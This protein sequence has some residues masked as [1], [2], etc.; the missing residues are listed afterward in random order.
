MISI[1]NTNLKFVLVTTLSA[2]LLTGCGGGGGGGEGGSTTVFTPT[3]NTKPQASSEASS[4]SAPK[5]S[6]SSKSSS[7]SNS[8]AS[9][10]R[11]GADLAAPILTSEVNIEIAE[12][13]MTLFT[14]AAA[15]DNVGVVAYKIYRDQI[16]IDQIEAND[17]LYADFNVAPNSDYTYGVSAGDA[18]GNWSPIKTVGARTKPQPVGSIVTSS[19]SSS[20][21]S[22]SL[23]SNSSSTSNPSS[24][25]SSQNSSAASSSSASIDTQAPSTPASIHK[26]SASAF[27]VDIGWTAASDNIGIASYKVYRDNLL[28]ATLTGSSLTYSDPSTQA[29]KTYLYGIE[30]LDAAGNKSPSQKTILV[31]TPSNINGD[32][33]LHWAPPTQ[34]ENGNAIAAT[35]LGGF[36]LRYKAKTDT[37][38][39]E[40]DIKDGSAKSRT[41][42]L[43]V[44]EYEFELAAYD[45]NGLHSS[46]NKLLPN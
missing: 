32:L 6:S 30:A 11:G 41:I 40:L 10:G 39:I 4:S 22:M 46:F 38:Y 45:T 23:A 29:I 7:V 13:D 44:G 16:Q 26:I 21:T 25:S 1:F 37:D 33:A 43:P 9:S 3:T 17:P 8:S 24:T 5:S 42:T 34:R 12:F 27:K 20:S 36:L 19:N 28:I 15:T 14:W 35:E 18:V 2:I 31:S